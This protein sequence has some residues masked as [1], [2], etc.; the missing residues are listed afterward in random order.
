MWSFFSELYVLLAMSKSLC[1]R[2]EKVEK[3]IAM[4]NMLIIGLSLKN[5]RKTD[6]E[7]EQY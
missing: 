2:H 1:V 6:K 5:L 4:H 3:S 7:E